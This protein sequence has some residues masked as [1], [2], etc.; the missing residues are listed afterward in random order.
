M[1][2]NELYDRSFPFILE[3]EGGYVSRE[4]A[5]RRNDPGGETNMGICERDFPDE[6]IK[7]LTVERVSSIYKSIYWDGDGAQH[8]YC[9][10]M[11]W[12]LCQAHLDCTVN[13][14]NATR[15]QD[16]TWK[17]TGQ[18]NKLLQRALG[19]TDDGIIGPATL[20]MAGRAT[21]EDVLRYINV[22][23][24]FYRALDKNPAFAGNLQ[25]WLYRC[26]EL[27]KHIKA[28]P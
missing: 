27:E 10:Q 25:G 24:N 28:N 2:P 13:I 5:K 21:L 19:T 7:N 6:D 9:D 20:A 12:P 26:N 15:R 23:R 22:R 1:T 4:Q 17:W 14:G 8:S 16:R 18:A 11:P 3:R